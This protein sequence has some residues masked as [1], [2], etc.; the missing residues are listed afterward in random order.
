MTVNTIKSYVNNSSISKL[1]Q[2]SR[3]LKKSDYSL[4]MSANLIL[5]ING[6]KNVESYLKIVIVVRNERL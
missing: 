4:F 5:K 2:Q 1:E 6:I 3:L